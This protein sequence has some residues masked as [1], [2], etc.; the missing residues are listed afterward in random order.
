MTLI[1]IYIQSNAFI[2]SIV[3]FKHLYAKD[4]D[5]MSAEA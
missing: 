2:C 3:S 1:N 4:S 5:V